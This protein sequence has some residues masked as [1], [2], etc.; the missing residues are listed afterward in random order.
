MSCWLSTH[1]AFINAL[2]FLRYCLKKHWLANN[3]LGLAF[4]IQGIE[5]LSLGSVQVFKTKPENS[6]V[7]FDF[8]QC[9]PMCNV[10]SHLKSGLG[11]GNN[12]G[13]LFFQVGAIMLVGLFV[14]DI[15]WVFCTPV[16]VAVAKSFDAPIKLLFPRGA[17][18][19][20]QFSMLGVATSHLACH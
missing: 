6:A 12:A 9:S 10:F 18:G 20:Q 15:F 4:S 7:P 16:M 5:H 3:L 2:V 13:R 11:V 1:E 14:Y 8:V 17:M 19:S